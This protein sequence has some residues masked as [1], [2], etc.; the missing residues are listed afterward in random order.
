MQLLDVSL[1][2]LLQHYYGLALDKLTQVD[3]HG[4]KHEDFEP[5]LYKASEHA[6]IIKNI[7]SAW[8]KAG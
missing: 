1:F 4:I 8:K 6:Y 7:K 5:L 2:G 3:Q